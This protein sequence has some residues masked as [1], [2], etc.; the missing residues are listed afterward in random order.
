MRSI[1]RIV[2]CLSL[3]CAAASTV[4]GEDAVA[5]IDPGYRNIPIP[6]REHGYSNFQSTSI[7]TKKEYTAFID[8]VNRQ[9]AWNGKAKVIDALAA[10]KVD[11]KTHALLLLRHTEGSGSVAVKLAPLQRK[12]KALIVRVN[13]KA[14][15]MGTAD[16]AYYCFAVVVDKSMFKAIEYHS[17]GKKQVLQLK[18]AK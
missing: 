9:R 1:V 16:M 3:V 10:A 5:K 14:P 15:E 6:K 12:G 11:F 8:A 17:K 7:L 2:A 4:R 18:P 13:R